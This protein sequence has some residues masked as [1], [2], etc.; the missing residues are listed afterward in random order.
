MSTAEILN[1]LS[2]ERELE[3]NV[4]KSVKKHSVYPKVYLLEEGIE[5]TL[6]QLRKNGFSLAVITNGFY[7]YQFPVLRELSIDNYL[8]KIL[9][10]EEMQHAKPELENIKPLLNEGKIIDNKEERINKDIVI[11]NRLNIK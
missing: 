2:L 6:E 3:I 11:K 5:D 8:D 4:E 10:T 1:D 7:K 9:T